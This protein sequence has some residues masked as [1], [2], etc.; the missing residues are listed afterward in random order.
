M[1]DN[2]DVRIGTAER[3][4]ALSNLSH[5]FS[6]GRLT[7]SEFDERSAAVTSA[8]TRG[9]VD[10][11]FVDLPSPSLAPA[12]SLPFEVSASADPASS[13]ALAGQDDGWDWRKVVVSAS[14]IIAL[15]L[16]FT[17]PFSTSWLFF[18]LVP[19]SGAIVYGGDRSRR[20]NH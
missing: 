2:P 11:V 4:Q 16:F 14:P 9:Q 12:E 1:A 10:A 5:H 19:L 18:L 20:G 6:A 7:I 15:I 8:A 17:V 13:S 3:E